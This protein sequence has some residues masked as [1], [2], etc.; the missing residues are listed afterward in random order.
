MI[1]LVG[2]VQY[3][4]FAVDLSLLPAADDTFYKQW[5]GTP[6]T[7]AQGQNN[8]K[9]QRIIKQKGHHGDDPTFAATKLWDQTYFVALESYQ[10]Y[11]SVLTGCEFTFMTAFH[12]QDNTVIFSIVYG[13][14]MIQT[15]DI[16]QRQILFSTN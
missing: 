13:D 15:A 9:C 5:A 4:A 7:L 6:V 10:I 12:V 14:S 11:C 16:A 1:E 8:I 2:Y 3:T